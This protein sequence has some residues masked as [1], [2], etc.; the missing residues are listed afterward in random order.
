MRTSYVKLRSK[1]CGTAFIHIIQV[2]G[3]LTLVND[4]P[5]RPF[6]D[7]LLSLRVSLFGKSA[8]LIGLSS[9]YVTSRAIIHAVIRR[10]P[11]RSCPA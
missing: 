7:R 10:T 11:I 3:P 2:S 9:I 8:D 4:F 1:L 5:V 6:S